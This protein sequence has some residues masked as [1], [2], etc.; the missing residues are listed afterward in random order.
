MPKC[1]SCGA[2]IQFITM[3]SGKKNPVNIPGAYWGPMPGENVVVKI[4]GRPGFVMKSP[5]P[6]EKGAIPLIEVFTS[7]FATCPFAGQYRKKGRK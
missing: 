3:E 1:K 6:T 7:H 2:E 5:G 4:H